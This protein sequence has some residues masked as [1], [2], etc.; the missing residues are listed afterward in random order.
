LVCLAAEESEEEEES[1]DNEEDLMPQR[2]VAAAPRRKKEEEPDPEQMRR[3]MER[4]ALIRQKRCVWTAAP[5]PIAPAQAPRDLQV[6]PREA[7]R[8]RSCWSLCRREEDRLKRIAQ[9]GFD[10]YAPPT[11]GNQR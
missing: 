11:D 10:R 5:V 2:R 1:S 9:E 3:D 6:V 8:L 7:R 4:L